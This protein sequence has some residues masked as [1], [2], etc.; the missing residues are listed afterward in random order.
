M[1]PPDS[2]SASFIS[3]IFQ[4][5]PATAANAPARGDTACPYSALGTL[6][7][8]D[9]QDLSGHSCTSFG[10]NG[11]GS[12]DHTK[13]NSVRVDEPVGID[14]FDCHLLPIYASPSSIVISGVVL[15]V[16]AAPLAANVMRQISA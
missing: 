11:G 13:V 5:R 9:L 14:L 3:Q 8:V 7:L 16:S 10:T 1:I 12:S 6:N 4:R 15:A 2:L